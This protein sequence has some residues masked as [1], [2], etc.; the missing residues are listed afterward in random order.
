MTTRHPWIRGPLLGAVIGLPILGGGGRRAMRLIA[1]L[2]SAAASVSFEG[3]LTVLLAGLASGVGGGLFYSLLSQLVPRH[4]GWRGVLFAIGLVLVTLRGLHPVRP[5]PLALF[6]PLVA[7]YGVV[8]EWAWHRYARH[9][10]VATAT[11]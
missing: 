8:F 4:R 6:L 11:A 10:R 9:P 1:V 5:L 2:T 7:L 3:T